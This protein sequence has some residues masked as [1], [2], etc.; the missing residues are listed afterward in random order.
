MQSQSPTI[1]VRQQGTS[2]LAHVALALH[3][4]SLNQKDVCR[5]QPK[6]HQHYCR[7]VYFPLLEWPHQGSLSYWHLAKWDS[8]HIIK[9]GLHPR[10]W[11][12]TPLILWS[13]VIAYGWNS[14][15]NTIEEYHN[16]DLWRLR[17][18][19]INHVGYIKCCIESTTKWWIQKL[20]IHVCFV[21]VVIVIVV[22]GF[23][24]DWLSISFI[25]IFECRQG[26]LIS[27]GLENELE[28]REVGLSC[29]SCGT[30]FPAT[31]CRWCCIK[32]GI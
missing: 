8:K 15:S 12:C 5:Y 7:D 4:K 16:D 29:K 24:R 25:L 11:L 14:N 23:F 3:M 32:Y 13:E 6:P 20:F 17:T 9:R 22:V 2:P 28:T 30:L 21:R 19:S 1:H 27:V 10:A 31:S 18:L 26:P